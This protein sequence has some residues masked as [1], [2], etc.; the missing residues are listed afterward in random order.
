MKIMGMNKKMPSIV[1]HIWFAPG[2]GVVKQED[3][4]EKGELGTST[5]LTAY[6]L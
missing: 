5:H 1:E 3:Y 4:D 2:I 6:K